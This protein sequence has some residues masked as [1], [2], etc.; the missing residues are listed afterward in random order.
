[1][2]HAW[3]AL[4]GMLLGLASP[5]FAAE[6]ATFDLSKIDRTPPKLPALQSDHPEYCLLVF[7]LDAH[8]KVWLVQDGNTLYVDRNGNGDLTEP[9]NRIAATPDYGD[10]KDG[11]F[12]FKA[13]DIPDGPLTHKDLRLYR[14]NLDYLKDEDPR[15]KKYLTEHPTWRGGTVQIDLEMP[16]FHGG[17]VEGRVV[18]D[19]GWHDDQGLL[20]F[21]H[22]PN[23]API[24]HFGG[25]WHIVFY[26]PPSNWHAGATVRPY[27]SVGT[28]GLGAGTT[29]FVQYQGLIPAD[30]HPTLTVSFPPAAEGQPA[31]Q[32]SYA[33]TKRCCGN[34]LYGNLDIPSDIGLGTAHVEL[35][36]TNWPGVTVAPTKYDIPIQAA[37]A[38][39]TVQLQAVSP[40][41]K[42]ALPHTAENTAAT[43]VE[44]Q[45]SSDGKRV[46]AGDYPG[47]TVNI[48]DSETAKRLLTLETGTGY[49]SSYHYFVVSPDWKLIYAPTRYKNRKNEKIEVEGKLLQRLSFDDSVRVFDL[50]TGK[51]LNSFKHS[52]PRKSLPSISH[53]TANTCSPATACPATTKTINTTAPPVCGTR[54]PAATATWSKPPTAWSRFP[55]IISGWRSISPQPTPQATSV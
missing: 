13:G 37:S 12:L 23:S 5:I 24:V 39:T 48:W 40:R 38:S 18:E 49:R 47:G 11:V 32:K 51:L 19:S 36:L 53:P 52:P 33:L 31:T 6:P 9:D 30:A 35:L 17:G 4:L 41:L 20:Q 29:A 16:D 14:F 1:M 25:P 34:N 10:P 26:N 44:V 7:G 22:D 54:P 55:Q 43:I 27:L 8:K 50:E 3:V 21:G 46:I 15:L 42:Q 45:F 2:R 28:P